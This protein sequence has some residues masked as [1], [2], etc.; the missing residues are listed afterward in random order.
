MP[1][2][3]RENKFVY[4][5]HSNRDFLRQILWILTLW[6]FTV[7]QPIYTAFES[8][9]SILVLKS[10]APWNIPIFILLFSFVIPGLIIGIYA[11]LCQLLPKYRTVI[12]NGVI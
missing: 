11:I 2:P 5:Y 12:L 6:S 7:A 3:K 10:F 4:F 8:K 1:N 9:D